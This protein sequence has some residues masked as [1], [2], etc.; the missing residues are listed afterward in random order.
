MGRPLTPEELAEFEAR[1]KTENEKTAKA[2]GMSAEHLDE[3]R[4]KAAKK[5]R[6]DDS[7]EKELNRKNRA[8]AGI[9]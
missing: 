6:A 4:R 9:E 5:V 7:W 8:K 3:I 2:L 1:R